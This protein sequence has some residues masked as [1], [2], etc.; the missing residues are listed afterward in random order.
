MK[1]SSRINNVTFQLVGYNCKYSRLVLKFDI[2][3]PLILKEA[4]IGNNVADVVKAIDRHIE[5][6]KN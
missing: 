5:F 2:S 3:Y 4:A 1:L 6:Q